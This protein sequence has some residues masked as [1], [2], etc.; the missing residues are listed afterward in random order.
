[1]NNNNIQSAQQNAAEVT[2]IHAKLAWASHYSKPNQFSDVKRYEYW[3]DDV[4]Q[5]PYFATQE[6]RDNNHLVFTVFGSDLPEI[7]ELTVTLYGRWVNHPKGTTFFCDYYEIELP[8]SK[9]AAKK[10]LMSNKFPGVGK[11]T[12]EKLINVF[13]GDVFK[14]LRNEPDRI[15]EVP[16]LNEKQVT[17][18]MSG[19]EHLQADSIQFLIEL[20]LKVE[21]CTKVVKYFKN[22]KMDVNSTVM[23]N[24][25]SMIECSGI[26]FGTCEVAARYLRAKGE[27]QMPMQAP[28]RIRAAIIY[29]LRINTQM[30]ND[31]LSRGDVCMPKY[32]LTSKNKL[33]V[34]EQSCSLLNSGKEITEADTVTKE[35]WEEVF[36]QLQ[37]TGTICALHLKQYDNMIVYL[38]ENL[39]NECSA[40]KQL[41]SHLQYEVNPT[42]LTRCI[43]TLELYCEMFNVQLEQTQKQAVLRSLMNRVS[44]ITGGPGT[45]KTTIISAIVWVYSQVFMNDVVLMAPT[46]K[47]ARRMEE[48]TKYHAFTIHSRLGLVVGSETVQMPQNPI[49]EG[50]TIIDESSMIDASLMKAVMDSFQF[51]QSQHVVFVGD[52]DQLPSVG[53]G[54]VLKNMIDSDVIPT[55]RLTK[56]FRQSGDQEAI[57]RNARRIKEGETELVKDGKS[58]FIQEVSEEEVT[59]KMSD[60]Y[61]RAVKRYGIDN[62]AVLCPRRRNKDG[63]IPSSA[64]CM[65]VILQA[66]VNWG[67]LNKPEVK[68]D[69]ETFRIGDRVMKC[70]NDQTGNNGDL[71]E[72]TAIFERNIAGSSAGDKEVMITIAWETGSQIEYD[73]ATFK[74]ANIVLAYAMSVHKSQ[75]SEY[76]CVIVPMINSYGNVSL[77]RNLLY[78]AVTRAKECV[79]L[80]GQE[81]AVKRAISNVSSE[82][83]MSMLKEFIRHYAERFGIVPGAWKEQVLEYVPAPVQQPVQPTFQ[84]LAFI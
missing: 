73:I 2:F 83:R 29:T 78:T 24:P 54:A 67:S 38:R 12:A 25:F 23:E 13:G 6:E 61:A 31:N 62:V 53:P 57:I 84:Q 36:D 56:I 76:P 27:L 50:L 60:Y 10:L 5:F 47:A 58:F 34:Y 35:Q 40:A 82:Y 46:G 81:E 28:E 70:M 26:G 37:T 20:G 33:G 22:L 42:Y 55:T 7:R 77:Q 4:K 75:G 43:D 49:H 39:E 44:I 15:S 14:I 71:G 48:S 63:K 65:N 66:T 9:G 21:Q 45:G 1:M 68:I 52:I 30:I 69:N 19:V 32:N 51:G 8:S 79:V 18:I 80:V 16:G 11:T 41:V 64:E 17:K 3:S 72:I 59:V 74:D